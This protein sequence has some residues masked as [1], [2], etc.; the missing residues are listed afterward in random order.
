MSYIRSVDRLKTSQVHTESEHPD[1]YTGIQTLPGNSNMIH[2]VLYC[3]LLVCSHVCL[4]HPHE[5]TLYLPDR[6]CMTWHLWQSVSLVH[7]GFRCHPY[8]E[9]IIEYIHSYNFVMILPY[10]KAFQTHLLL[11][12]WNFCTPCYVIFVWC[13]YVTFL[14]YCASD[15]NLYNFKLAVA[16]MLS[17]CMRA[18]ISLLRSCVYTVWGKI[19]NLSS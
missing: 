8:K 17:L 7:M 14:L 2:S 5:G 12:N 3:T 19:Y 15:Y 16:S 1:L 9:N 18:N 6:G 10:S 4:D 13:I 11:I